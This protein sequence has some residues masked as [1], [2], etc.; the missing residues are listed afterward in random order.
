MGERARSILRRTLHRDNSDSWCHHTKSTK[1][2]LDRLSKKRSP[3][4]ARPASSFSPNLGSCM[5]WE[6]EGFT[7]YLPHGE[8]AEEVSARYFVR[9][10]Q[11]NQSAE[12]LGEHLRSVE[13][14]LAEARE[15]WRNWKPFGTTNWSFPGRQGK[16][17]R[18]YSA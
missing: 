18:P 11:E 6:E 14:L 3:A 17:F 7:L 4:R 10:P 16:F 5:L 9:L 1:A 13:V 15:F 2:D 8:A 12:T